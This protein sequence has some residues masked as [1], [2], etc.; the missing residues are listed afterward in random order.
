MEV[1]E[2]ADSRQAEASTRYRAGV[3][4]RL[5][6]IETAVDDLRTAVLAVIAE[7]RAGTDK[8]K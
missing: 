7:R 2:G 3:A 1:K 4:K 8:K 6:R 5:A